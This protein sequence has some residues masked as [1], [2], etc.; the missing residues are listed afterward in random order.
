MLTLTL[1]HRRG[2]ALADL[3]DGLG[4][5]WRTMT[6]AR[7]W[8]NLLDVYGVTGTIRVAEVTHGDNGWHVHYHVILFC[9]RRLSSAWESFA[10]EA[11]SM[12]RDAVEGAGFQALDRRGPQDLRVYRRSSAASQALAEYVSKGTYS[13][14]E[15]SDRGLALEVTR[16]DMKEG[17][18][19][20][21]TPFQILRDLLTEA[22]QT[23]ALDE[24]DLALWREYESACVK[25][26]AHVWSNG[27]RDLLGVGLQVAD[28]EIASE[29]V[30]TSADAIAEIPT[31][32]WRA[33]WR[34]RPGSSYDLLAVIVAA[35][36][37]PGDDL[38][39]LSRGVEACNGWLDR[40][41][42][43]RVRR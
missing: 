4:T 22:S 9:D 8:R 14:R 20:G 13:P 34:L 41:G 15:R 6:M 16:S 35:A 40:H 25:R 33:M 26:K 3:W 39:R 28:E 10:G 11:F 19:G 23:G 21:R 7:K 12:W 24:S 29:E 1:R 2:Q 5:A 31:E 27:L 36:S 38:D 32:A 17:K 43:A 37:E 42:I 18:F 30:G